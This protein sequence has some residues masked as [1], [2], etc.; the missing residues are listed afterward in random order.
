MEY[1]GV[2]PI[3]VKRYLNVWKDNFSKR[4]TLK[5]DTVIFYTSENKINRCMEVLIY[6][7]HVLSNAKKKPSKKWNCVQDNW[8]IISGYL[9]IN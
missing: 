5:P 4:Q 3:S 7:L 6:I 1:Q 2:E 8:A 9:S